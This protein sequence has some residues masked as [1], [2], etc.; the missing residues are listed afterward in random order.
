MQNHAPHGGSRLKISVFH[1]NNLRTGAGE[2]KAILNYARNLQR[3]RFDVTVYQT[4]YCRISN[5]T[6]A[7]INDYLDGIEL[8][9]L[10]SI[11]TPFRLRDIMASHSGRPVKIIAKAISQILKVFLTSTYSRIANRKKFEIAR[12]SDLVYIYD[13]E[14]CGYVPR[15]K[16]GTP[17]VGTF[18]RDFGEGALSGNRKRSFIA[19]AIK[20]VYSFMVRR[21]TVFHFLTDRLYQHSPIHRNGDFVLHSGVDLTMFHPPDEKRSGRIKFL[22]VARLESVKGIV[23]VVEAF[24]KLKSE[25]AELHIAGSGTMQNYVKSMASANER[26]FYDGYLSGE[27]LTDIYRKCDVFVFPTRMSEQHPLVVVEAIA[28]GLKTIA[29]ARLRGIFD[30]FENKGFLEYTEP[31]PDSI[32]LK[33]KECIEKKGDIRAMSGRIAESAGEYGWVAITERLFNKLEQIARGSI[34]VN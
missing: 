30:T 8:V 14:Y 6:D 16:K 1:Y 29:S 10:K 15:L 20:A 3:D 4:D 18:R 2:E 31:E 11:M 23:D 9:T 25:E 5:L 32:L 17:I 19:A 33:M 28:S 34:N 7:D 21:V 24:E 12:Q 13:A 26:I 22:F 27:E